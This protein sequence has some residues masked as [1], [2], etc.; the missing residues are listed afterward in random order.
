V[1][2]NRN[3]EGSN[4]P[5]GANSLSFSDLLTPVGGIFCLDQFSNPANFREMSQSLFTAFPPS[6]TFSQHF[7]GEVAADFPA[8]FEAVSN[9]LRCAVNTS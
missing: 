7:G 2:V 5:Q 6:D 9:T 4:P 1:C 3:V 8:A